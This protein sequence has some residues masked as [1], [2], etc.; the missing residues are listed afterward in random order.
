MDDLPDKLRR[1]VVVLSAAIVAVNVFHLSFKPS[2]MLLGFAEVGHVTPLKA[3]LALSAVLVYLFLRYW[4]YED[5]DQELTLLAQEFQNRRYAA[6]KR[7]LERAL[8]RARP[9]LLGEFRWLVGRATGGALRRPRIDRCG[10][11]D[12]ECRAGQKFLVARRGRVLI[13]AQMG[14]RQP[15]SQ[16]RRSASSFRSDEPLCGLDCASL[17]VIYSH[18]FEKRGRRSRAHCPGCCRR[19]H[20]PL[21]TRDGGTATLTG[22]FTFRLLRFDGGS[23]LVICLTAA[24]SQAAR[25]SKE[26]PYET[27]PYCAIPDPHRLRPSIA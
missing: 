25:V 26:K 14:R 15:L 8:E 27:H 9:F 12:R 7:H 24:S 19:N 4:F 20:L 16:Q 3:W 23:L 6:I 18:L 11:S 17:R 13:R 22:G 1:N 21:S 5:T 10:H 2:G